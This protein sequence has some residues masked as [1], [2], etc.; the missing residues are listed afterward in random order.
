MKSFNKTRCLD[1]VLIILLATV[2]M[3]M[4]SELV[5]AKTGQFFKGN[6]G[7]AKITG[8]EFGDLDYTQDFS[9]ET[10]VLIKPSEY[11]SW[12]GIITKTSRYGLYNRAYAGWGLGI[13]QHNK[14]NNV[15]VCV[16]VGDGSNHAASTNYVDVGKLHIVMTWNASARTVT[17]FVNGELIAQ[18]TN[19]NIDLDGI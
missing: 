7:Y 4:A 18:S 19:V 14:E 9:V 1:H 2:I 10:V 15:R 3:L 16:K 6:G 8:A 17:L 12:S 5:D 11:Q 13:Y